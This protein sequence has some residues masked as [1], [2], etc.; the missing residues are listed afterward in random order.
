VVP[1][2]NPPARKKGKVLLALPYLQLSETIVLHI[3]IFIQFLQ[4][5]AAYIRA[6]ELVDGPDTMRKGDLLVVLE[7][8]SSSFRERALSLELL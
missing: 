3:Y 4:Q 6:L 5:V 1:L 8:D 2:S 7:G